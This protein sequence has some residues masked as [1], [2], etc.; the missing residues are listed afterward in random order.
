MN[1]RYLLLLVIGAGLVFGAWKQDHFL[2]ER[3]S[4]K[5]GAMKR[6]P[7]QSYPSERLY[8]HTLEFKS[9]AMHG[10]YFL[11]NSKQCTICHG[12]NMKGGASKIACEKCH[13]ALRVFDHFGE[14]KSRDTEY[15]DFQHG[16]AYYKD[17]TGCAFCHGGKF[18]GKNSAPTCRKCHDYPHP[19]GWAVPLIHGQVFL[20]KRAKETS[21][22]N[23]DQ[24]HAENSD[25]K[26][27]HP[28]QFVACTQCHPAMPHQNMEDWV[29]G[30][31]AEVAATYEGK[32]LSCHTDMKRLMPNISNG[33]KNS[34]C[35]DSKGTRWMPIAKIQK[36]K[37][38]LFEWRPRGSRS[39]ASSK[40]WTLD[41]QRRPFVRER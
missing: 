5:S 12:R 20:E 29:L 16:V 41:Y 27:R 30:G 23:C 32:C 10:Q 21:K 17:P 31:H 35:H 22:I 40:E 36:E 1:R 14:A 8:P 3:A 37:T 9:T 13:T 4:H 18:E 28:E 6:D 7:A 25:F 38:A 39:I 11:K 15:R 19:A 26:S 34:D 33:C 2:V 24:C